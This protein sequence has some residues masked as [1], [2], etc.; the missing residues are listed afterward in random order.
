MI[1][2]VLYHCLCPYT[3]MWGQP[4]LHFQLYENIAL[5]ILLVSMPTFVFI[6]GYLYYILKEEK[7]HYENNKD[8][9]L[10]KAK[11]LLI[12]YILIGILLLIIKDD[13]P[14]RFLKNFSHLW[15]LLMLFDIF[16]FIQLT[17]RFWEGKSLKTLIQLSIGLFVTLAIIKS[18]FG[19]TKW[20]CL[21]NA[22]KYIPYFCAGMILR[23][24][25]IE[26]RNINLTFLKATS[27]ISA[28]MLFYIA[29]NELPYAQTLISK[30]LILVFL[31]STKI[32]VNKSISHDGPSATCI[33][34][35]KNCMG[36]Y[37]IHHIFIHGIFVKTELY[38]YLLTTYYPIT[39]WLTFMLIFPLSL[40]LSHMICK[41][42]MRFIL[43]N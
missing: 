35:D 14:A 34:L 1:L 36:I 9:I 7:Q 5:P 27:L 22:V 19:I 2:I 28:I 12:P 33:L 25:N 4:A 13:T 30:T 18:F 31:F 11:R 23:K 21:E 37:L 40:A 17:R 10:K 8:F 24:S 42:K 15:F 6:S 32:L 41:T 16:T 43:G 39:P 26:K 3:H 20:L 38:N 29:N